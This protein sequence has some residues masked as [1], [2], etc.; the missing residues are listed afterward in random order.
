[1]FTN[2]AWHCATS[3]TQF[4][5]CGAIPC[6]ITIITTMPKYMLCPIP[7]STTTTNNNNNNKASGDGGSDD[8]SPPCPN[9]IDDHGAILTAIAARNQALYLRCL[10]RLESA[11]R[12]QQLQAPYQAPPPFPIR[13]TRSSPEFLRAAESSDDEALSV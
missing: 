5:T 13:R 12:E 1:M 8:P 3:D 2:T 9:K 10:L 7:F 11:Q 4:A 6:V